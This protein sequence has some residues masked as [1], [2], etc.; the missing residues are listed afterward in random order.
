MQTGHTE[1]FKKCNTHCAY[2]TCTCCYMYMGGK[3]KY[4]GGSK[5]FVT[6]ACIKSTVPICIAKF[7]ILVSFLQLRRELEAIID[8]K[9]FEKAEETWKEYE[10]MIENQ[11]VLEAQS[12]PELQAL[13]TELK[14]NI[15]MAKDDGR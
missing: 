13:A 4:F 7:I 8:C 10:S 12:H 3:S 14:T 6:A 11:A 5:Y 1:L 2:Y 9:K 15:E